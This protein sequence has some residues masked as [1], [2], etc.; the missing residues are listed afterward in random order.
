MPAPII[1]EGFLHLPELVKGNIYCSQVFILP[2][3][4][5]AFKFESE[6]LLLNSH[7]YT[8]VIKQ[9]PDCVQVVVDWTE[10]I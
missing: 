3:L 8:Q 9:Y 1:P 4:K 6:L 7:I 2:S 5:E 10:T